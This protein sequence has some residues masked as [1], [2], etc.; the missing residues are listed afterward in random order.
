MKLLPTLFG[1]LILNVVHIRLP[2]QI[3]CDSFL[4]AKDEI[5]SIVGV[6]NISYD[7]QPV[8][9]RLQGI[10][11]NGEYT[12]YVFLKSVSSVIFRK[13]TLN[14][15]DTTLSKGI[16][17]K[18]DVLLRVDFRK[19]KYYNISGKI[20]DQDGELAER[21]FSEDLINIGANMIE[22]VKLLL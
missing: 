15:R 16:F 7:H 8:V 1:I 12:A 20:I 4:T 10:D 21:P 14:Y 6:I 17:Y 18:Q 13:I 5:D 11:I 9:S 2:A 19:K 3:I 22:L